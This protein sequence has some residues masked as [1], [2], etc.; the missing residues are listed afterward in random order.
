VLVVPGA[1]E[2]E[3]GRGL[4]N[5]GA[6]HHELEMLGLN[7]LAALL[8]ALAPSAGGAVCRLGRARSSS[9]KTSRSY[10]LKAIF[11]AFNPESPI[12]TLDSPDASF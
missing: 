3:I 12:A 5:L 11:R 6:G 4:A 10:L 9:A 8:Q 7:V 2:H 1:D